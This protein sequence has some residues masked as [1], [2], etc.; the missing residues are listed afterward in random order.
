ML[1]ACVTGDEA[2]IPTLDTGGKADNF[3]SDVASEYEVSGVVTLD[4]TPEQFADEAYRDDYIA[5]RLT[6]VG[7]Y[8]TTFVTDKFRGIDINGDGQITEDEVFFHNEDYGGYHAMVRNHTVEPVEVSDGEEG[9]AASFTIDLAGPKN[10]LELL[11]AVPGATATSS[12]VQLGLQMPEGAAVDAETVPRGEIRRFD[13]ADATGPLETVALTFGVLVEPADAY[14]QFNAFMAD[15]VFDITMFYG[16]DYNTARYDL[17]AARQAY[18]HLVA[19]GFASP[20]QG[21][22]AL[23]AGSGPLTGMFYANGRSI[24][25]EVRIFHSDMFTTDRAGQ[26]DLALAEMA[27]RDVFFYN[28]HA[29]PYYGFYLDEN[30]EATVYY[31]EFAGA[32]FDEARQQLF[33]A[34]GCQ[35]YSQYADMVYANPAK[36]E[37]NLDVIVTINYSYSS[38]TLGLLDSLIATDAQGNHVPRRFYEIVGAMNADWINDAY[39]VFYGVT[40][41]DGNPQLHPYANVERLGAPCAAASECGDLSGNACVSHE[42]TSRCAVFTLT[43]DAC[44]AG[45][46]H[47]VI[48]TDGRTLGV[49][50]GA[51]PEPPQP[52]PTPTTPTEGEVIVTEIMANPS[53]RPD[54]TAEW[55]EVRNVSD[56]AVDLAGCVLGDDDGLTHTIATSV[57]VEPG[58]YATLAASSEPGFVPSAVYGSGY[59]I[60]N[61]A[62]EVVLSCGGAVID[63]VAYT[64]AVRNGQSFSLPPTIEDAQANDDVATWCYGEAAYT[65]LVNVSDRGTP[66]AANPPCE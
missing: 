9:Y 63:R 51:P 64:G 56:A 21:F 39:N 38:G 45:S 34:Q 12:T 48:E 35:T 31:S 25:L 23:R 54:A 59:F 40:G 43:A 46:I 29:G 32:P 11:A 3:Y 50:F 1:A 60:A 10:L 61:R 2:G 65:T 37:D 13:P 14:P 44:P 30:D 24:S 22:D 55:I 18:D 27:A 20:V 33:I 7:L 15:G 58:A 26:H 42:G 66:G 49:C 16:H 5:R 57:V 62:D 47:G 19:M 41:I 53:A 36:S 8:L 17:Q 6:A 4:L 52:P 28:G